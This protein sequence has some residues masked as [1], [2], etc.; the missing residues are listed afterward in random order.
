MSAYLQNK[1]AR[2]IVQVVGH[3]NSRLFYNSN[4][5]SIAKINLI[6][7]IILFLYITYLIDN[8]IGTSSKRVK[9]LNL[10][11]L[12]FLINSTYLGQHSYTKKSCAKI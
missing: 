9:E 11:P 6:M 8:S 3:W 4:F 12:C 7:S 5:E 2:G 1:I 10:M